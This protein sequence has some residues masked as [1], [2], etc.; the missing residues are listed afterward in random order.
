[1]LYLEVLQFG[2]HTLLTNEPSADAK[3]E[4]G[5]IGLHCA[6]LELC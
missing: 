3:T 4:Y 6:A 5:N 1:M 2:I